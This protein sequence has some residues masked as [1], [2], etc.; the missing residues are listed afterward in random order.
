[1]N[2]FIGSLIIIIIQCV[3]LNNYTS[4]IMIMIQIIPVPMFA[5]FNI[6][7]KKLPE[8]DSSYLI[9]VSIFHVLRV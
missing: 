8:N 7:I 3:P 6:A 1:M 5:S 9:S 2:G 4:E